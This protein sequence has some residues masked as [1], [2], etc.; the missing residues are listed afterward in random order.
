LQE[1]KEG[2]KKEKMGFA[3]DQMHEY[4]LRFGLAHSSCQFN[5]STQKPKSF[6]LRKENL[7][8][9]F[10][11]TSQI[12]NSLKA[13]LAAW[14]MDAGCGNGLGQLG[15]LAITGQERKLWKDIILAIHIPQKA[16]VLAECGEQRVQRVDGRRICWIYTS[17]R[18]GGANWKLLVK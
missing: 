3:T 13:V 8:Q 4:V 12:V 17:E 14:H 6:R 11:I 10:A 15:Q 2:K 9:P 7:D 16:A 1:T 18:N 5:G